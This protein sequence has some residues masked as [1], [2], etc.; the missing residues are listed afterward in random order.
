M[1]LLDY[2]VV[3]VL[4]YSLAG[5]ND[6]SPETA[7]E[8]VKEAVNK[9]VNETVKETVNEPTTETAEETVKETVNKPENQTVKEAVNKPAKITA[10]EP[11]KEAVKKT[12]NKAKRVRIVAIEPPP[13]RLQEGWKLQHVPPDSIGAAHGLAEVGGILILAEAPAVPQPAAQAPDSPHGSANNLWMPTS[14][15]ADEVAS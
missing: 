4:K 6:S 2:P 10:N 12:V 15:L 3:D 1:Y 9:P 5:E 13:L 14:V 11:V 7:N 8:T